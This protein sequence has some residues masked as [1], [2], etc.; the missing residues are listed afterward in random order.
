MFKL[1]NFSK[2]L[3]VYTLWLVL[4]IFA[5]SLFEVYFFGIGLT[6]HDIIATSIFWFLGAVLITPFVKKV[7]T[8]K[9][10]LTGILIA[11]AAIGVL[12]FYPIREAAYL[13]RFLVGI[14]NIVF[15]VPFNSLFYDFRNKNNAQMSAIYYS[16]GPCL[17]IILP[18]A[19]GYVAANMGYQQMYAISLG[20]AAIT[21][22]V[23]W[24]F[25]ENKITEYNIVESLN[26]IAGLRTLIF[27]EGF[28]ANLIVS[29]L[30]ET[31]LLSYI[32]KP[33]EFGTFIGAV[34]I[35]SVVASYITA[36][37]SDGEQHRRKYLILSSIAFG[38][39]V[40]IT[41]FVPDITG[42]FIGFA[43]I[44]FFRTIYFPLPLALTV[45]NTTGIEKS[46]FGREF[47]LN[48]GRIGGAV[49]AYV[50]LFFVDLKIVM[51]FMGVVLVVAYPIAFEFKK[52]K[53]KLI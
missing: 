27:L 4:W 5:G 32:S 26:S 12:Y 6:I 18:A 24:K 13:F 44:N 53:L 33:L 16:I 17:S 46:M 47:I 51:A 28:A 49:F 15:W 52:K 11:A 34:T 48:I 37:K 36:R 41:S 10:M 20:I 31:L 22:V 35:C 3:L 14:T 39:S 42:F 25:L 9:F 7:D 45:D 43:L 40:I 19:S 2:L 30:L 1:N 50:A 8:K 23:A 29:A 21:F 38:I